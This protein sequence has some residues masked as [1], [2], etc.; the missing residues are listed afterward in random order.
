MMAPTSC[1]PPR[2]TILP[3]VSLCQTPGRV[4]RADTPPAA[5]YTS[6][7]MVSGPGRASPFAFSIAASISFLISFSIALSSA[8]SVRPWSISRRFTCSIGSRR[9]LTSLTCQNR[10]NQPSEHIASTH[11]VSAKNSSQSDT[12]L[13]PATIRATGVRHRVP[14]I[15]VRVG[16]HDDR[17]VLERILLCEP[18]RLPR[19]EHIHTVNLDPAHII[20]PGKER[21]RL[22]RAT[23]RRPHPIVVVF[24]DKHAWQIPQRSQV[25]RLGNLPDSGG[26]GGYTSE[27]RRREVIPS[28]DAALSTSTV[29]RHR[30]AQPNPTQTATTPTETKHTLD[31]RRHRRTAPPQSDHPP[32]TGGQTPARPPEAPAHPQSHSPHKNY[33][34][35]CTCALNHPSPCSPPSHDPSTRQS[36]CAPP[37][38]CS[39]AEPSTTHGPDN[40]L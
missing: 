5:T 13:V 37:P 40:S 4:P 21:R 25:E 7:N 9:A 35:E 29:P 16:L 8:A 24:A 1:C 2:P 19:R 14:V 36:P 30:R 15:A 26:R 18:E 10:T 3:H 34:P 11:T 12:Y 17:T 23:L 6:S 28:I 32:Y 20:T 39:P 38:H 22:G 33:S 27:C 31:W